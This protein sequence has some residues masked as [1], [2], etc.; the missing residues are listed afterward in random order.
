MNDEPF[1][2][3]NHKPAPA[4]EAKP[5]ELLFEFVRA[6]NQTRMFCELR[7]HG[8]VYGWE[9]EFL[10]LYPSMAKELAFSRGAWPS[11]EVAIAWAKSQRKALES[12]RPL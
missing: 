11:R 6:S 10:E 8:D 2:S 3:P 12:G 7:N 5:G 4:R 1:Y 9:V